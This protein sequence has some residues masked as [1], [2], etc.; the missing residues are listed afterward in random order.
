MSQMAAAQNTPALSRGQV[1][2]FV[3]SY[4]R[5]REAY[6]AASDAYERWTSADVGDRSVA[7]A[8]YRSALKREELAAGAHRECVQRISGVAG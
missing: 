3:H 4:V 5:W 6:G 2:E 7:F 1:D 8:A